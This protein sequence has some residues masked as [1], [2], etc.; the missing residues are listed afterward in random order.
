KDRPDSWMPVLF[1]RLK[2]G[3][4]WTVPGSQGGEQPFE[5]WPA[6]IMSIREGRCTPILGPGLISFLLDS[7]REIA[8]RWADTYRFPMAPRDREDLP[9]V[10][11]YLA[12]MQSDPEFPLAELDKYLTQEMWVRYGSQLP[13]TLRRAPLDALMTEV[14][15]QRRERDEAEPH[16]VLA[17]LP[18]P[19][20]ITTNPVNLLAEALSATGDPPKDPQVVLCRWKDEADWPPS[21]YDREP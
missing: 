8:Q 7:P 21:I 1:T 11:Q 3:C 17:N 19:I 20:Y 9:Q 16:R 4:I 13:D 18:L 5:K 10:A 2:S 14:G 15:R 12:V 6:L